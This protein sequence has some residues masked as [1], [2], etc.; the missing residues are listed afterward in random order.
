LKDADH[1][2]GQVMD[3]VGDCRDALTEAGWAVSEA[4]AETATGEE[5][6]VLGANGG[7]VIEA[8]GPTQLDAWLQAVEQA[9]ELGLI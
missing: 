7:S 2:E 9:R 1:R 8:R 3:T 5:W 4:H 6:R